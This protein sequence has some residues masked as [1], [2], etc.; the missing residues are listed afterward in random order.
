M[1]NWAI[2]NRVHEPGQ[3]ELARKARMQIVAQWTGGNADVL[4]RSLRMTNESFADYLGVAVRTVAYWRKRPEMIPQP[5]IQEVLDTALDKAPERAKAQFAALVNEPNGCT[6]EAEKPPV[7]ADFAQASLDLLGSNP[8]ERA[9]IRSVLLRPS[10]LDEA[11]VAHLT[12]A[13]YGQ[14]HAEDSL[15]PGI[16]IAPME[17]QL[18]A[19]V[20]AL[21]GS[22]GP[23]R[24]ALMRLVADWMTFIGWL[25]TALGGYSNADATF[26][27]AEEISDELGDGTLA[28]IATSYRGYIALLQGHYRAAIRATAASIATPGAPPTQ[29]VYSTLQ[30][31]QAYAGLGDLQEAK[32][33]LRRASDLVTTAGDPPESLYWY[34]EPFLRMNI[35]LTQH[36]IGQHRDAVDSIR[37][38]MAGLPADQQHAEWLDEYHQALDHAEQADGPPTSQHE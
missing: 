13:L 22:S 38:G 2:T 7:S 3:H 29:V 30:S 25:H 6:V 33:L 32:I 36:S 20:N 1:G 9:R 5:H 28:S 4:R 14:R 8:D 27:T 16:M 31:A 37:S 18:D 10:R 34:T 17:A 19:L 26:A 24:I 23:H 21:R 35:G 11:T 12:H 15:G